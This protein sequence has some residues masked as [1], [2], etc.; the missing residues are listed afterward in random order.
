MQL[1]IARNGFEFCFRSFFFMREVAILGIGQVPAGEY[2]DQSLRMMAGDATLAALADAGLESVE[3]LFVGNMMSGSANHQQHLGA[4]IA[5]WVG[6]RGINALKI[7]AACGSGS[8]AMRTA[9]MA[10]ASGTMD[11]AIA[12]G[13]EKMTDSP[14]A[15]ITAQLATAADADWELDMG[16]SF[17]ALNALMMRRYMHEYGW[18]HEDFAPFS[19]NAHANAIHNRFARLHEKL[20]VEKFEKSSIVATPINL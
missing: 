10:V 20:T 12:V 16:L 6:L 5:D 17:V 4:Y 18:K 3:G 1:E 11:A 14:G 9:F 7:E 2:W 15:E 13:V 8:A 19:I